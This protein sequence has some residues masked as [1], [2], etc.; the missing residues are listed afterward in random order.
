[1]KNEPFRLGRFLAVGEKKDEDQVH[2]IQDE[3]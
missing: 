1:M 3:V 2:I